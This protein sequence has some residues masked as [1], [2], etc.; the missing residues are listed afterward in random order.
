LGSG[1]K[2]LL[3]V[4]VPFALILLALLLVPIL[5]EDRI[6][7]R[8][9]LEIGKRV[10]A[11][12]D[13]ADAG[14]T[15]FRNFPNVTLTL[16]DLS[17]LGTD[18]FEGDTLAFV[19]RF[20]LVLDVGTI[21][22]GD[23]TVV[24]AIV[25]DRP[26]ANLVVL[27]DGRANWDIMKPREAAAATATRDGGGLNVGLRRLAVSDA[28]I[29][30]DNRRAGTRATL[31]DVDHT[32]RGDFTR[33]RFTIDTRTQASDVTVNS[34]GVS[35][36][37]GVAL[38]ITADI[39]ADMT[40][41]R[42][43]FGENEVRLNDLLL[44]FTGSFEAPEGGDLVIDVDFES[45]G[46]DFAS[47]LSLVPAIYASD[48]ESLETQGQLSVEG[49]IDGRYG[50]AAFPALS[51][52]AHVV[53]ASLKYPDLPLP[54]R[55]IALDLSI[56]NPGGNADSTVVDVRR[57]HARIGD[58]A[59]AG[60]LIIRTPMSDPDIALDVEGTLDL[61]AA[62]RTFRLE[63]VDELAG[64]VNADFQVHARKSALAAKRYD[65]VAASGD[66]VARDVTVRAAA[67][68]QPVR[69][70]ELALGISPAAADLRTLRGAIG[71]S[72][73]R[74]TGSLDNLL[75]FA[76]GED[77]LRGSATLESDRFDL[78]EWKS[79]NDSIPVIRVP[80]RIDF[81]LRTAIGQLHHGRLD[82]TDARGIVRIRDERLTMD[83]VTL[84]A[85]GGQFRVTGWYDTTDPARPGFDID[86]AIT[87]A[88][89][90]QSFE[91]LTTVRMFAPVARYAEGRFSTSLH[92]TGALTEQMSPVLSALT[93]RGA[94][95]TTQLVLQNFPP[96][97]RLADALNST[98]LHNPAL[99]A[100]S[101]AIDIRDGRLHVRPFDV[102]IG[103]TTLTVGGSNGID[104]SLDYNLVL[105]LP[106]SSL[107]SAAR[108]RVT[109]LLSRSG[110]STGL[111][112]M[113]IVRIAVRMAGTIDDPSIE[114]NAGQGVQ[115]ALQ[116]MEQAAHEAVERT[117]EALQA[118]ADS[119]SAAARR[120]AEAEA[121]RLI[122][123]AQQR[124]D[125]IRTEARELAETIRR[126]AG[127]RAD[128]L[129][130][131]ASS[132]I[133]R[134]AAERAASVLRSQADDRANQ[135]TGEAD[136]RANGIVE[137]ARAQAAALLQTGGVPPPDTL[138]TDTLSTDTMTV[139]TLATQPP[140]VSPSISSESVTKR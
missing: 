126:E 28:R 14:L 135:I 64:I 63:A 27:A 19:P 70:D 138:S 96:M 119:A 53:D 11:R 43:T 127:E 114:L 34:G 33:D 101:T 73:V 78:D 16:E 42:F 69:I 118:R 31:V 83:S 105:A 32:L 38:D 48:F 108:Q 131:S 84:D 57:L 88:D 9:R 82:M 89:V 58:D 140:A 137:R 103:P 115:N 51:I 112:S 86:V 4:G 123:E 12:V 76:L 29:V 2:V 125:V 71:S 39:D 46:T 23:Q 65:R 24:R 47:L 37:D 61:G 18:R 60:A 67:L 81:V 59:I 30:F 1:R 66:I 117:A 109:D 49:S 94:L 85:V 120:R 80:P 91:A 116:S 87:D 35:W 74:A 17:V 3:W 77:V 100:I 111:D 36:L 5:F 75:G 10:D 72:D 130:A 40:A 50:E 98:R 21:L 113:S 110:V 20:R 104:R 15:F 95:E 52:R 107:E 26:V 54:A 56:E 25:V 134:I 129:V 22:F 7:A 13:W 139:D 62:S 99:R 90:T 92:L 132:P 44:A 121:Q 136:D 97:E 133:A 55:D 68:R 102:G 124:A 128:S 6:A 41:R 79:E 8:A 93:G 45:P 122:D 106:Q